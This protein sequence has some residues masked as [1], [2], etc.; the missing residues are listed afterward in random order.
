LRYS[1][2]GIKSMLMQQ[3]IQELEAQIITIEKTLDEIKLVLHSLAELETKI[4]D[5]EEYFKNVL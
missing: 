3:K 1:A 4:K 2:G 5:Q